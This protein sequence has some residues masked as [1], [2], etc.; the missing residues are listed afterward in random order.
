[1]RFVLLAPAPPPST[2]LIPAQP[3][4]SLDLHSPP[5]VPLGLTPAPDT[6]TAPLRGRLVSGA[7]GS[8]AGGDTGTPLTHPVDSTASGGSDILPQAI[9]QTT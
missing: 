5:P 3:P 2:P 7:A 1:A 8:V 6:T 4:A 9:P